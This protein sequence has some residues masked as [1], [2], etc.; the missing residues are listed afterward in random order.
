MADEPKP[1]EIYSNIRQI[2][3]WAIGQKIVDITQHDKDEW[4]ET[5]QAYVMIMLENGKWIKFM[6]GDEGFIDSEGEDEDEDV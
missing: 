1:D 3:N 4:E 2:L 6:I 5:K